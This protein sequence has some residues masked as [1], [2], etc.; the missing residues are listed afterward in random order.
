MQS[1]VLPQKELL[2][3]LPYLPMAR[4]DPDI[5]CCIL[6]GPQSKKG[7]YSTKDHSE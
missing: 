5:S 6:T 4:F 7:A 2:D 1:D 3:N